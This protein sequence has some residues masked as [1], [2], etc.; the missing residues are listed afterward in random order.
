MLIGM[1]PSYCRLLNAGLDHIVFTVILVALIAKYVL[2]ESQGQLEE[3]LI[4]DSLQSP[5]DPLDNSG[6]PGKGE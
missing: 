5:Q 4:H 2:F 3:T 1:W 6:H